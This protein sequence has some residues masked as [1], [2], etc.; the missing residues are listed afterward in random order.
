MC[1]AIVIDKLRETFQDNPG[2]GVA[3][4]YCNFR[5]HDEETAEAMLSSLLKQL[6]W[7]RSVMPSSLEALHCRHNKPQGRT[8]PSFEEI[9]QT[10]QSVA[11]LYFR[12]FILIDAIDEYRVADRRRTL[13]ALFSLQ[14]NTGA[15]IFA[16]SRFIPDI[17][18]SFPNCPRYEIRAHEQDVRRY[19]DSHIWELPFVVHSNAALQEEIKT[20]IIKAIDGMY[21]A[22]STILLTT[23]GFYLQNFISIH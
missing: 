7:Q 1:T 3:Y 16:T 2:I 18:Q 14:E 6:S 11:S 9:L 19:L 13:S 22:S 8:R 4:L 20:E 21:A 17:V 23:L 10:L 15:N 12:V 5:R